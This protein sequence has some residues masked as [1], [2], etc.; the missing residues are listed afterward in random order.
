MND[1]IEELKTYPK[2]VERFDIEEIKAGHAFFG[3]GPHIK[4]T[5]KSARARGRGNNAPQSTALICRDGGKL[6]MTIRVPYIAPIP[7]ISD[8]DPVASLV[9]VSADT[10][11]AL[12]RECR[13]RGWLDDFT[14]LMLSR[15]DIEY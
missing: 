1:P 4:L 12:F 5:L 8:H 10:V 9:T 2:I 7:S 13:K 6:S 14:T 11:T 15:P 3:E